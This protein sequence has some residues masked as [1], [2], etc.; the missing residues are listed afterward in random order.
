[1]VALYFPR[2]NIPGEFHLNVLPPTDKFV[3]EDEDNFQ[4]E[5]GG[6]G[7]ELRAAEK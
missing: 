5:D 3:G 6:T 4:E 2:G 7:A 1:M